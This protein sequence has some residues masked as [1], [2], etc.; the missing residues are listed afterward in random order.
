MTISMKFGIILLLM[1]L[2]VLL[3]PRYIMP[4]CEYQGFSKMACSY[5]GTAEM[6][7]GAI[8]MMA[9]AGMVLSGSRE[10]LRWSGLTSIAAGLSVILVPE[11]LGYCHNSRMPCNYGTI[12]VLRLLGGLIMFLSLAGF[13]ISLRREKT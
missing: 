8:V 2:L 5:T 1:G 3:T 6:F 10:T 13:L 9:A 4:T 11:A 12:P 7:L